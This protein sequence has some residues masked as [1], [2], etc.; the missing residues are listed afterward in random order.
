MI[1]AILSLVLSTGT[2]PGYAVRADGVEPDAKLDPQ[3]KQTLVLTDDGGRIAGI[4][5]LPPTPAS[6]AQLSPRYVRMGL[7]LGAGD[8]SKKAFNA[9]LLG[10]GR[11]HAGF[12]VNIQHISIFDSVSGA[13][14]ATL[15][16]GCEFPLAPTPLNAASMAVLCL[17][18]ITASEM[19]SV[20]YDHASLLVIDATSGQTNLA[21]SVDLARAAGL[22]LASGVGKF[23]ALNDGPL[24]TMVVTDLATGNQRIQR[25]LF[26]QALLDEL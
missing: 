15:R 14:T 8:S 7:F 21:I 19:D 20:R 16:T 22:G 12:E 26:T 11:T 3:R 13:A 9:L 23:F 5:R 24:G 2:P 10:R 4:E 25:R 18:G 17:S 1:A 6:Y